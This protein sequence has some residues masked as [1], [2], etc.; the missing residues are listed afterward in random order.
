MPLNGCVITGKKEGLTD[1]YN[2]YTAMPLEVEEITD[3]E[4]FDGVV[5]ENVHRDDL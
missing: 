1:R 4:M 3:D 5:I 2:G